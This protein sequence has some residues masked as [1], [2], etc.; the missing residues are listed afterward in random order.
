MTMFQE[1]HLKTLEQ[2]LWQQVRLPDQGILDLNCPQLILVREKAER[3]TI[4][5]FCWFGLEAEIKSDEL[6]LWNVFYKY[7]ELQLL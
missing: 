5:A 6:R 3:K 1:L 4:S 2:T 7:S